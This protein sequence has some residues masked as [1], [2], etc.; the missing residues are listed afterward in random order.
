[1]I[2]VPPDRK[3]PVDDGN[4]MIAF[5]MPHV[6][7]TSDYYPFG[8]TIKER[9]FAAQNTRYQFNGKEYDNETETSHLCP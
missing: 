3:L 1:M 6:I 2:G 4:G 7:S 9:T 8:V 5:Y